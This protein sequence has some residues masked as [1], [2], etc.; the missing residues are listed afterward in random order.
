MPDQT[1]NPLTGQHWRQTMTNAKNVV[2]IEN[3]PITLA[4]QLTALGA[5]ASQLAL[6]PI[7]ANYSVTDLVTVD[8]VGQ[9]ISGSAER[10]IAA[11]I[12]LRLADAMAEAGQHW[13]ECVHREVS[14]LAKALAPLKTE[15][16]TANKGHSNPSTKYGRIR[17]YGYELLNPKITAPIGEE[18]AEGEG[19]G[20]GGTTSRTRDLFARYVCELGKLYRAGVAP[21]NDTIIKNHA[22]GAE[23]VAALENITAALQALGAP[24]DD[25]ELKAYMDALK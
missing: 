3:G 2:Q 24:L 10:A 15:F 21:D 6:E 4:S 13:S 18:D 16:F 5:D 19:E 22:R 7:V 25:E 14:E 20:A 12:N 23:I 11:L 17:K 9:R 8:H 1:T